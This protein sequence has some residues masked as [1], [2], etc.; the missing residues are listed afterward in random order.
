MNLNLCEGGC[1]SRLFLLI[2][3]GR[4]YRL[5]TIALF[6]IGAT[7]AYS[8]ELTINANVDAWPPPFSWQKNFTYSFNG[9]ADYIRIE[10]NN[11]QLQITS[12][13]VPG[14]DYECVFTWDPTF[15]SY[16]YCENDAITYTISDSCY[17]VVDSADPLGTGH[18]IPWNVDEYRWTIRLEPVE[19]LFNFDACKVNGRYVLLADGE[20]STTPST[21]DDDPDNFT[22]SIQTPNLGCTIAAD[23]GTLTVSTNIGT[24]RVKAVRNAD[25]VCFEELFDL[26]PLGVD[27]E[28]GSCG[29]QGT[30]K[31]KNDG[32]NVTLD[33]GASILGNS[34]GGLHIFSAT[35]TALLATPSR[36]SYNYIRSDVESIPDDVTGTLRQLM[37]PETLVD[38]H[39]NS[40]DSYTID[41]YARTNAFSKSVNYYDVS[42]AIPLTSILVTN[43]NSDT[44]VFRFIQT[45]EGSDTTHSYY[46]ITNGWILEQ[47][48]GLRKLTMTYGLTE[49]D[50]IKTVTNT[51]HEGSSAP[52]SVSLQKYSIGE[53]YGER[54]IE[55][56]DAFGSANLTN[57]Y[58]YNTDGFL[59]ESHNYDGSWQVIHYDAQN[60]P[61]NRFLPYGNQILTTN[62]SLCRV[63]TYDYTSSPVAGSG[64]DATYD[65]SRARQTT[66]YILDTA[67]KRSYY[68]AMADKRIE[69]K[70]TNPEADWDDS[71]NSFT[72]NTLFTSGLH[73]NEVS[74]IIAPDKTITVFQYIGHDTNMTNIV[75]TGKANSSW[76][77][78]EDGIKTL[79][80]VHMG[81]LVSSKVY[82]IASD[83]NILLSSEVHSYDISGRVQ[84]TIYLDG[85]S[86]SY[87]YG[88]CN[89]SETQDRSGAVTYYTYDALNRV[90]G[91]LFNGI[92]HSNIYDAADR[93]LSTVRFGNDNSTIMLLGRGYDTAG[94]ILNTTNA[95]GGHTSYNY[96]IAPTGISNIVT[97]PDGGT[98]RVIYNLD[99]TLKQLDGTAM[100]PKLYVYGI[101]EKDSIDR[102][103]VA[104]NSLDRNGAGTSEWKTN[105]LDGLDRNFR[106]EFAGASPPYPH[107]VRGYNSLGQLISEIEPDGITRL[108]GYDPKGRLDTL[109]ISANQGTNAINYTADRITKLEQDVTSIGGMDVLRTRRYM[110]LTNGSAL[111][112]L[113][114]ET[115]IA[116]D[117]LTSWNIIFNALTNLATSLYVGSGETIVT[118]YSPDGSYAV[119]T[120]TY[121]QLR[122]IV[123]KSPSG[124]TLGTSTYS[125]DEHGRLKYS[126][127]ARNG[128][129]TTIFNDGDLLSSRTTPDPG[130]G[131]APQTKAFSYDSLGRLE[132]ITNPDGMVESRSYL[133]SGELSTQYGAR[134][135][136]VAYGYDSQGRITSM[137]NWTSYSTSSGERVTSWIYDGYQGYLTNKVYADNN[138]VQYNNS[139]AG[140]LQ[141][142]LWQRGVTSY[143][144]NNAFGDLSGIGYSDGL[145]PN[146]TY[147]LDRAG[148]RTG[149]E[150]TGSGAFTL[151]SVYNHAGQPLLH[152]YTSGLLNGTLV[153]NKFDNIFRRASLNWFTNGTQLLTNQ[154]TYDA[155]SRYSNVVNGVYLANFS[156]EP[157]SS[158]T[159]S[160]QMNEDG[161]ERLTRS[162]TYDKLAR[163]TRI[164]NDT[165]A[166]AMSSLDYGYNKANQRVV[167]K[168]TDSSRWLF[169][170]DDLGQLSSGKHYWSDSTPIPGQQFAYSFDDI[171]NRLTVLAGGNE[172]GTALRTATYE[173]NEVNQYTNRT[174]SGTV[175]IIGIANALS[176]V[177]V[178][179]GATYRNGEYYQAAVSEDNS[180]TAVYPEYTVIAELDTVFSTN[181]GNLFI[182]KTPQSFS[183]DADGNLTNDGRWAFTWD[184]ENRLTSL[185]SLDGVPAGA[186][187]AVYYSYDDLGRRTSKVISNWTGSAWSLDE[188]LRYVYDEWN[189]IGELDSD[190]APV[191]T[192]TWGQ[193]LSGSLQGAGGVGGLVAMTVHSGDDAGGYF[194][195]Y[196]GNGNVTAIVDASDGSIAAEYEYDPFGSLIR[197][198][199]DVAF[200]NRF[201]FSTKYYDDES[202]FAYYGHRF[203]S[204]STGRWLNRDPIA[205]QGGLNLYCYVYNNSINFNDFN[206]LTA[207]GKVVVFI[208]KGTKKGFKVV[209]PLESIDEAVIAVREGEDIVMKSEKLAREVVLK[210]DEGATPIK[211]FDQASGTWH[212]HSA[213][214]RGGHVLYSAAAALTLA[215]HAKGKGCAVETAAE[216]GDLV[217]PASLGQDLL[218]IYDVI[219]DL[220]VPDIEPV[221]VHTFKGPNNEL[222]IGRQLPRGFKPIH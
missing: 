150:T 60:R 20:S 143:Y 96:A 71:S 12:D 213:S 23:T 197:A 163:L 210:A 159:A 101:E 42:G 99:G 95:L 83:P 162:F 176:T 149:V 122:G 61:I 177:E 77:D 33:L 98:R 50:T 63:V 165:N 120:N 161:N 179:E 112:N 58:T 9:K 6:Y 155:F 32:V 218:D 80:V 156:Y 169:Q 17:T 56:V 153:S 46:W 174:G 69:I 135:Y 110:W 193:D 64:D 106:T 219:Y 1:K 26:L 208:A 21:P 166:T 140:R 68:I 198:T 136:P 130:T 180:N 59:Y 111:S 53:S 164:S 78:V 52:A 8:V 103:Y 146:V 44:N 133:P 144:T 108:Y 115:R 158:L 142:R 47:G 49:M 134:V 73:K 28:S 25:S 182:P 37:C 171:G 74:S 202:H 90:I 178:N 94:R 84:T 109:A 220:Y 183:Y 2:G 214:R 27:C 204:P 89:I 15:T 92:T 105:Y 67:V 65:I 200:E 222:Y 125:Y 5:I 104:E 126:Y 205:E 4:A 14:H 39:T 114:E 62:S 35:P 36:I 18:T 175:D 81:R 151:T 40:I 100:H 86:K 145:T 212:Y 119:Q 216:I 113:V 88:C 75:L 97:Y 129:S 131:D 185:I 186:S 189:L 102:R 128:F 181:Q 34:A 160:I 215:H 217:N 141:S 72:T 54:L 29:T 203:Y 168:E 30:V 10:C 24:I 196:D 51:I 41:F 116:T 192:Y 55:N 11:P 93:I 87:T 132:S 170:Y 117:G 123:V 190:G 107:Y 201:R 91:E 199:G 48:N 137:T 38:I 121:G 195:S 154:Y 66:E 157:N 3:F 7:Q 209:R 152:S 13:V 76:D 172:V 173:A 167:R 184:A 43:L 191:R 148:R 206:G 139:A 188:D 82:D 207:I 138:S 16:Q 147:T 124:G 79:N 19:V 70:C 45:R 31:A 85:T 211:E 221:P 118:N 194:F 57:T 187:N 22:W 127:E